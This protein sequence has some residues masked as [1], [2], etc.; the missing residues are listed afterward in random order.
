M[1][2]ILIPSNPN[3]YWHNLVEGGSNGKNSMLAF[4]LKIF[5]FK[6]KTIQVILQTIPLAL[7]FFK[8]GF[9]LCK[10]KEVNYSRHNMLAF[11]PFMAVP[12]EDSCFSLKDR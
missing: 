10:N 3:G 12:S 11:Q 4:H 9:G 7:L 2:Y 1:L 6:L 8:M 5:Y